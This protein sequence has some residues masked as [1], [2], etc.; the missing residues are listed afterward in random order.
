MRGYSCMPGTWGKGGRQT[1][2]ERLPPGYSK[3][4]DQGMLEFSPPLWK[5]ILDSI[6]YFIILFHAL[7]LSPWTAQSL[8]TCSTREPSK[9]SCIVQSHCLW[10]QWFYKVVEI[11]YFYIPFVYGLFPSSWLYTCDFTGAS[12]ASCG[13]EVQPCSG[14]PLSP[15]RVGWPTLLVLRFWAEPTSCHVVTE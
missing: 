9:G 13:W 6:S 14:S 8:S 5:T 7:A 11:P 12:E 10:P 3:L 15:R 2:K 1:R 4:D